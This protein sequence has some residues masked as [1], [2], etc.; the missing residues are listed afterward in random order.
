MAT[1]NSKSLGYILKCTGEDAE[2]HS[3]LPF[4][5]RPTFGLMSKDK[6]HLNLGAFYIQNLGVI[7]LNPFFQRK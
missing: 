1:S 5:R 4:A 7:S 6:K 3:S 2:N